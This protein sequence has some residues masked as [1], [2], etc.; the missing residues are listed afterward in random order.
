MKKIYSILAGVLV[1]TFAFASEPGDGSRATGLAVVKKNE[2]TFNLFYQPAGVSNVKVSIVNSSGKEI[3]SE[4]I[5]KTDGFVRPYNFERQAEGDYTI[6]V[7]DGME[8]RSQKI[9]YQAS[10]RAKAARIIKL[11]DSKYL[12]AI[13][14]NLVSGKVNIKVFDGSK[15]VHEQSNE[16]AGDFG[17][18]FTLKNAEETVSFEVTNDRGE[19]I[20]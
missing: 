16:I 10:T 3:F 2:T 17:Q 8:T 9:T 14:G 13:H 19:V 4:S 20:N 18:V 5:Y 7:D 15:L 12:L 6:T 1:S 11:A